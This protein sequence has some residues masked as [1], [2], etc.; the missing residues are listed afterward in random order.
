MVFLVLFFFFLTFWEHFNGICK[1]V[2]SL[3]FLLKLYSWTS[4]QELPT[5]ERSK[6]KNSGLSSEPPVA[7]CGNVCQVEGS[8]PGHGRALGNSFLSYH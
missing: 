1:K 4:R 6:Q 2:M 5:L 8:F 3:A 7:D